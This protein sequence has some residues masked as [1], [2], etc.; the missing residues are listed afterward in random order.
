MQDNTIKLDGRIFHGPTQALTA[1]QNDYIHGQLGASGAMDLLEGIDGKKRTREKLAR[2]LLS[3]I[4]LSGRKSLILAGCLTEEGKKWTAAEADRNAAIFGDITDPEEQ[5]E[6]TSKIVQV[7]IGFFWSG[8]TSSETFRKSSSR[9][10]KVPPTE[11]EAPSTS[12][13][14]PG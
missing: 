1:N 5:K 13:T 11:N 8:E 10:G 2:D 14:S 3:R 7:V 12:A 9:S 4:L 6:M